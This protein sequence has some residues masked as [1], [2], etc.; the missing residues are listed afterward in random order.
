M[1]T[2]SFEAAAQNFVEQAIFFLPN[3]L[4]GLVFL[5]VAYIGIKAFSKLIERSLNRKY[6]DK[7]IVQLVNT[8]IS[9][10]LWFAVLLSFLNIMGLGEIAASL[11]TASGFLA[12]GVAYALS[13]MIADTVSGYYLA[14][15]H[16]FEIGDRVKVG[17]DEGKVIEVGLRKSR[18]LL[19]NSDTA[20]IGNS[21]IE[22]KW[23]N[24]SE[25][26]FKE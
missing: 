17:E 19:D 21:E 5:I 7:I 14:K 24:K 6:Q 25:T 15:D 12:L 2:E 4:A 26:D 10:F 20:V 23:V 16:D 13:D 3:L 18:L 22:Q 9:I 8:I 11:G 1:V